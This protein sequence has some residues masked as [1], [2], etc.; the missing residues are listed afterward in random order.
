MKGVFERYDYRM[1]CLA[2]RKDEKWWVSYPNGDG[3]RAA[4]EYEARTIAMCNNLTA[5]DEE[6]QEW[7][8]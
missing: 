5:T 1:G 8:Q 2:V 4:S 6:R 3:Q 7:R